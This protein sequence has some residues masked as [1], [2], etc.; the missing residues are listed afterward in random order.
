MFTKPIKTKLTKGKG[1][2]YV[3][4]TLVAVSL[5]SLAMS[6]YCLHVVDIVLKTINTQTKLLIDNHKNWRNQ[7]TINTVLL[8]SGPYGKAYKDN[9]DFQLCKASDE[10]IYQTLENPCQDPPP[11]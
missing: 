3:E 2:L 6:L 7:V 4:L 10:G 11:E 1:R 9:V 8:N 5:F